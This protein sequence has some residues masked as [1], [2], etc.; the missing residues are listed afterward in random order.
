MKPDDKQNLAILA[1]TLIWA[2]FAF[3]GLFEQH[4][5]RAFLER[6]GIVD[7]MRRF[8]AIE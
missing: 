3:Y 5:E 2:A 8:G 1:I 7:E 4:R 6:T